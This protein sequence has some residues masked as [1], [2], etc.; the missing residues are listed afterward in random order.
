MGVFDS[1]L[2]HINDNTVCFERRA[3]ELMGGMIDKIKFA[4]TSA[5]KGWP[6]SVEE[7]LWKTAIESG[8][9]ILKA[10]HLF[11]PFYRVQYL[12]GHKGEFCL[13]SRCEGMGTGVD[14][15]MLTTTM[16]NRELCQ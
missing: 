15:Q 7:V 5:G 16:P 8:V 1:A 6:L 2:C 13:H 14:S 4:G 11:L 10:N 9:V 3:L 12:K